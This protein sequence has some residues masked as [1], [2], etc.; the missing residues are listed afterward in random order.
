MSRIPRIYEPEDRRF[1]EEN[2][3]C[4]Y[5]GNAEAFSIN[6][7]LRHELESRPDGIQVKLLKGFTDRVL[8]VV[9]KNVDKILEKGWDGRPVFY[10]ANCGEGENLDLQGRTW[11]YCN[12][13]GCP[14]CFNCG[15][16]IDESEVVELC[17]QCIISKEGAIEEDDCIYQCDWYDEGLLQVLDHYGLTVKE[18]KERL[19]Y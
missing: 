1:L 2:L 10:C 8:N 9:A 19:G 7:K 3:Y 12:N 17:T 6:L 11:E 13:M 16:W 5:C 4:G 14:G 15:N 18:L